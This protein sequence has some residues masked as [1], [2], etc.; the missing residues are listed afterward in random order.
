MLIFTRKLDN[1]STLVRLPLSWHSL[2]SSA[3]TFVVQTKNWTH[4]WR[5]RGSASESPVHMILGL[6]QSLSSVFLSE[7]NTNTGLLARRLTSWSLFLI[8]WMQTL[9]PEA[10]KGSKLRGLSR[11]EPILTGVKSKK[12]VFSRSCC[13]LSATC[14]SSHGCSHT[15]RAVP[16][17]SQGGLRNESACN[18][19]LAFQHNETVHHS[20]NGVFDVVAPLATTI[21]HNMTTVSKT[22]SSNK[23]LKFRARR[24][25]FE[26]VS[27]HSLCFRAP[28]G[29]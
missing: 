29:M 27:T 2:H 5:T 1:A 4:R 25:I 13:S 28:A 26:N 3:A 15:K 21:K 19:S 18:L 10:F 22:T 17:P 16:G 24:K 20:T 23:I 14:T 7:R 8:V 12:S 9:V 11:N 6:G